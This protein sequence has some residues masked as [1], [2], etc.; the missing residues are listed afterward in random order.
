MKKT[1]LIMVS[2]VSILFATPQM[3]N[4][5]NNSD[6]TK[7]TKMSKKNYCH[8]KGKKNSPFLI[9]RGLPHLNKI[10][11]SYYDDPA[12]NLTDDQKVQLDKIRSNTMK[13]VREI[14][15]KVMKLR[16]E[17]ISASL[18]GENAMNLKEKVAALSLLQSTA[19]LTHLRCIEETKAVLTKDQLLYMFVNKKKRN[20]KKSRM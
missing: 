6:C 16:K 18:S 9:Q 15:P 5:N 19:T 2:T 8:K 4:Q 20:R 7:C 10:I 1:A 3:M 12:F 14:K 17:I 11:L 13:I